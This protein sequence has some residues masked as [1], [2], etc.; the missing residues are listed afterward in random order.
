MVWKYGHLFHG[1]ERMKPKKSFRYKYIKEEQVETVQK[2]EPFPKPEQTYVGSIDGIRAAQGEE[3]LLRAAMK[4]EMITGYK[5][6]LAVGAPRNMPGYKELDFLLANKSGQFVAIQVRDTDFIHKG[7]EMEAKDQ[8]SDVLIQQ[9][10]AKEG[11]TL[12]GGR[13]WTINDDQLKTV[14]DAKKALE[15][16]L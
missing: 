10:L 13:I 15:E 3:N 5:F 4:Y 1:H 11:I 7:L 16:I 6:R 14:E 12:K 8:I 9:N 2:P